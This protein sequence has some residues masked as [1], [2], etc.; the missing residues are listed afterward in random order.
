MD[1][2][3]DP[4]SYRS[5]AMVPESLLAFLTLLPKLQQ[6]KKACEYTT[7]SQ[8]NPQAHGYRCSFHPGLF[9]GIDFLREHEVY[10]T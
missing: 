2:V 8:N 3:R 5:S 7:R 4:N 9:Q 1:W 10:I 6:R